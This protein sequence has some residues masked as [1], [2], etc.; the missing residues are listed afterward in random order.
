MAPAEPRRLLNEL[1]KHL[2]TPTKSDTIPTTESSHSH[3]CMHAGRATTKGAEIRRR[4][5]AGGPSGGR[6]PLKREHSHL[7]LDSEPPPSWS[8][9]LLP[10]ISFTSFGP[11][12]YFFLGRR[13]RPR[14]RSIERDARGKLSRVDVTRDDDITGSANLCVCD[15]ERKS[16]EI[17]DKRAGGEGRKNINL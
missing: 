16:A 3:T 12:L 10:P 6:C 5:Y 9:P 4:G 7:H 8:L 14:N 13:V 2:D 17:D 15:A 1:G 11:V